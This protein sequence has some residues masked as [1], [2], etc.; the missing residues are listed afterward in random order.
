[1]RFSKVLLKVLSPERSIELLSA[2]I[3]MALE[4]MHDQQLYPEKYGLSPTQVGTGLVPQEPP[5]AKWAYG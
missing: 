3:M 2:Q 5:V 4:I 1:V